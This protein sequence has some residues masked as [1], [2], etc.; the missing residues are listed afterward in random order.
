MSD[1]NNNQT[2]QN[3]EDFAKLLEN[4]DAPNMEEVVPG[5]IIKAHIVEISDTI[6]M[7]D[8]GDKLEGEIVLGELKNADGEMMFK[9][10]DEIYVM[11]D[12]GVT[13][14]G[15][16]RLSYAKALHRKRWQELE[17][18]LEV[19]SEVEGFI[20]ESIKG[21]FHVDIGGVQAFMPRSQADIKPVRNPQRLIGAKGPF[22]VLNLDKKRHT[23]VVSRREPLELFE[24]ERKELLR[25]KLI[26]G[27][28]ITGVVKNITEYG[29]FIDLEGIDGLLH[30]SDMAW[31]RIKDP[32][33]VVTVGESIE[34]KILEYKEEKN[35]VSL[36]LKQLTNDPWANAD[37]DF[38]PGARLQG[39]VV[40]IANFG[41]FVELQPGVE[42]MVHLGD[43]SW[44]DR[45]KH[46][47]ENVNCWSGNWMLWF[48]M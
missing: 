22:K 15:M 13:S 8:I 20:A 47:N 29:A 31:G 38:L 32:S 39:K 10:G 2:M 16:P 11:V 3:E 27:N 28:T 7:V 41:A 19:G 12:K 30:V 4:Y 23:I 24:K 33:E 6:A 25:D 35:R 5:K 45:L 34:V 17:D 36:G 9:I 14:S 43:L 26:E 46:P 21:G 48:W 44:T 18:T 42:G 40:S 37:T 1:N